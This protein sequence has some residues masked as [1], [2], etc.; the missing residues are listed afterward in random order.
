MRDRA[1]AYERQSVLLHIHRYGRGKFGAADQRELVCRAR[2]AV[3]Q[4][5]LLAAGADLRTEPS[6]AGGTD[7]HHGRIRQGDRRPFHRNLAEPCGRYSG[8]LAERCHPQVGSRA[9]HRRCR[10]QVGLHPRCRSLQTGAVAAPGGDGAVHCRLPGVP[11]QGVRVGSGLLHRATGVRGPGIAVRRDVP[12]GYCRAG[13]D[14]RADSLAHDR[15][16]CPGWLA[17]DAAH[18]GIGGQFRKGQIRPPELPGGDAGQSPH[19]Q[20]GGGRT[21]LARPV[22]RNVG[23]RCD[24]EL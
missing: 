23:P 8:C 14:D 11:A 3:P 4:D 12:G 15:G 10:R 18:A 13:R 7:L 21:H 9:G 19:G 17:V 6:G 5:G 16:I 20:G 24:S 2:Q 22:P 1:A